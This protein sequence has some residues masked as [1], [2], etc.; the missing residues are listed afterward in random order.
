[1]AVRRIVLNYTSNDWSSNFLHQFYIAISGQPVLTDVYRVVDIPSLYLDVAKGA[2]VSATV[3]NI[4][5]RIDSVIASSSLTPYIY[6]EQVATTLYIYFGTDLVDGSACMIFATEYDPNNAIFANAMGSCVTAGSYNQADFSVEL[7]SA[8]VDVSPAPVGTFT[9][10][11]LTSDGFKINNDIVVGIPLHPTG[12]TTK[13][14]IEVSNLA[15]SRTSGTLEG[16]AFGSSSVRFNLSP[17][18]KWLLPTPQASDNYTGLVPFDLANNYAKLR[19]TMRRYYYPANSTVLAYDEAILERTFLRAGERVNDINLTQAPNSVLRASSRLPIWAGYPTAEYS[20]TA[21][22]KIFKN[23][24]LSAVVFK[25]YRHFKGCDNAYIRFLNQYGGYSY[26]LFGTYKPTNGA[27]PQGYS[28]QYNEINDFGAEASNGFDV[29]S[30]VQEE[31]I[32][33]MLDLIVSPEVHLYT[34]SNTWRR[35]VCK[36]NSITESNTKRVY[37]VAVKF[38]QASTF[39]PST[40]WT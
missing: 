22:Y 5:T 8:P 40:L 33:L 17:V 12:V 6:T 29:S 3:A 32:G 26:W 27:T 18:A 25:E 28:Q 30:K 34:G 24:D 21:D 39:N 11:G 36:A 7:I 35:I 9:P 1:M 4:K 20:L 13:A 19:I 10:E 14:T 38:E 15:T 16:F 37:D 2:S 23:N 31:Y